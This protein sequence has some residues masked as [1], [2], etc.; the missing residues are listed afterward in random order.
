MPVLC[1]GWHC[2]LLF[3]RALQCQR[4]GIAISSERIVTIELLD[5]EMAQLLVSEEICLREAKDICRI[6]LVGAVRYMRRV[7]ESPH[8][9]VGCE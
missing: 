3:D 7:P 6:R 4:Q 1:F 9:F 2:V 8:I 5:A